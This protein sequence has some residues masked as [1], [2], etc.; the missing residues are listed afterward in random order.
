[1]TD[2]FV[3]SLKIWDFPGAPV[4]KNLPANAGDTGSNPSPGKIPHAT[5]Q[6]SPGATTTEPMCPGAFVP[7]QEKPPQRESFTLQQETSP[8][9]LHL[10]KAHAQHQRPSTV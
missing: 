5:E 4:V 9:W 6:P 2:V 3:K 7:Q 10:E 1:M 8:L